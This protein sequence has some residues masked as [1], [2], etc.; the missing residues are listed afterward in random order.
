MRALWVLLIAGAAG[1]VHWW[2]KDG[3]V[4]ER[5]GSTSAAPAPESLSPDDPRRITGDKRIVMIAA[6]WCG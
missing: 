5:I 4:G 1:G 2:L 6:D 3:S